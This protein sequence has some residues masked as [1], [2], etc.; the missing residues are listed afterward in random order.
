MAPRPAPGSAVR[1]RRA[2]HPGADHR[3]RDVGQVGPAGAPRLH[4][5]RARLHPVQSAG[6]FRARSGFDVSLARLRCAR[7][8]LR[9]G[10]H[11]PLLPRR[12]NPQRQPQM[13]LPHSSFGENFWGWHEKQLSDSSLDPDLPAGQ[14]HVTTPGSALLFASLCYAVAACPPRSRPGPQD[15][16]GERSAMMPKRRRTRAQPRPPHRHRTPPQPRNPTSRPSRPTRTRPTRRRPTTI[17]IGG[18]PTPSRKLPEG[19]SLYGASV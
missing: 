18:A 11:D 17:M 4:P 7:H 16:C 13:L 6:R 14:T 9:S 19:A 10:P 8:R 2:D 15:Y 3:A 1:R 5:T 12:Q